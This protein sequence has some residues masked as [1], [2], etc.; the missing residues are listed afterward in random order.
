MNR[1]ARTAVAA[2]RLSTLAVLC[3]VAAVRVTA[4]DGR[5]AV[6]D[7]AAPALDPRIT[8][9]GFAG[10]TLGMTLD[11]ARQRLKGVLFERTSD[12]DG[13]ALVTI[14]FPAGQ[15]VVV[16][17]GE[18]D[19]DTAIDWARAIQVIETFD[20]HFVTADGVRVGSLVTDITAR[21]GA[22]REIVKSEIES[23]QYVTFE[24][25]PP[26]LMLRI[27]HSGEFD[28]ARRT[29]RYRPTARISSIAVLGR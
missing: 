10:L 23:R 5:Q 19:P 22:V 1:S 12:G 6:R 18:D 11:E 20:S 26:W 24:R 3:A 17:A 2:L 7:A 9:D 13:A 16:F 27:D 15:N 25:Q 14:R 29:T 21:L 8:A 28:G 4:D